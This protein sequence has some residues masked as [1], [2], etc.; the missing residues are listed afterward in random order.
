VL[1]RHATAVLAGLFL[2]ASAHAQAVKATPREAA[3]LPDAEKIKLADEDIARMRQ[4]LKQVLSRLE[5]ARSEK[6][7][8]KLNC[9]NEKLTQI[10]GLLRVSE[11]AVVSLQ[12]LVAGKDE[13]AEAES[14]KITIARVKVDQLHSEAEECIG[15]LAFAVDERTTVEVEQP[16]DLPGRDVTERE[17]PPPPVTRPPPI[18]RFE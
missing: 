17:P 10:K 16:A 7:V 14:A 8:V 4:V 11:Q 2:G 15:Q 3:A 1:K 13:G 9:V 6:D 18:S 5:D 12:D